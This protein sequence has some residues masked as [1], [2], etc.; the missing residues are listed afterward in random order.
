MIGLYI[1]IPFC[2]KRCYYCD[3]VSTSGKDNLI[4][5]YIGALRV[6]AQLYGRRHVD[7]VYIGGGTPSMLDAGQIK[8]LF[9]VI[10][11][12]FDVDAAP[13]ITFEANPDT[14]TREKLDVL[15][16]CGVT[17]LSLGFQSTDEKVLRLL[18]RVHTFRE[19]AASFNKARDAGF[20]N[21]SVD[22]IF[23]VPHQTTG[24]WKEDLENVSCLD[25]EHISVYELTLDPK[26]KLFSERAFID[27]DASADMYEYAIDTLERKGYS[28]Y[29]ISNFSKPGME[30]AHNILYWKNNEYIGI[31]CGAW[32]YLEGYRYRNTEELGIYLSQA[33]KK[34]FSKEEAE[35]LLAERHRSERLIMGLCMSCGVECDDTDR[36]VLGSKLDGFIKSGIV[37]W[38]KNRLFLSKKGMNLADQ[39]LKEIV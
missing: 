17:R 19:A 2:R 33:S 8:Q 23:G 15:K 27:Q 11:E 14:I 31:G 16:N 10:R 13:E 6:E 37:K 3:F 26:S 36:A 1:H 12:G 9:N 39:V 29:E 20:N 18:G 25:P 22:L 30:C 7:T 5:E 24:Q 34:A 35:K 28:R 32:S 4:D 38:D 21:I